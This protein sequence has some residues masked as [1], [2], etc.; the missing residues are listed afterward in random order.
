M[1]VLTWYNHIW[2]YILYRDSNEYE[3]YIPIVNVNNLL[4]S[5]YEYC[6]V[7]YYI[8]LLMDI[9]NCYEQLWL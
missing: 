5:K 9:F 6:V 8:I 3:F 7:L 1:S 4:Y 2:I